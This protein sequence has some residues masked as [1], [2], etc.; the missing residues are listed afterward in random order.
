MFKWDPS[1]LLV[2]VSKKLRGEERVGFPLVCQSEVVDLYDIC[3]RGCYK[4]V[5][6]ILIQ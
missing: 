3:K 1:S 6:P 2:V 5:F 4:M